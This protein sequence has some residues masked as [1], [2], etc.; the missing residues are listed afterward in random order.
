MSTEPRVI[1]AKRSLRRPTKEGRHANEGPLPIDTESTSTGA[2]MMDTPQ[3][4]IV[5]DDSIVAKD[6]R[7]RL[8]SLGYEVAGIATTGEDAVKKA[9][10]TSPSLILMDIN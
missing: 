4:M 1:P 7:K 9:I 6:L 2:R 10:K 5:E 8:T 3:I